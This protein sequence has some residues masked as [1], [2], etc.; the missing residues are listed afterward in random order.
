ME[1]TMKKVACIAAMLVVYGV[2]EG[3]KDKFHDLTC[4]DAFTVNVAQNIVVSIPDVSKELT[5]MFC[6]LKNDSAVR[7]AVS[8]LQKRID[9]FVSEYKKEEMALMKLNSSMWV[10]DVADQLG[11]L[12]PSESEYASKILEIITPMID[13]CE[14]TE[15]KHAVQL[16]KE[17]PDFYYC[18]G[19][20]GYYAI[21]NS[22]EFEKLKYLF[23]KYT[24]QKMSKDN[25]LELIKKSN[26]ENAYW[27]VQGLGS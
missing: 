8:V 13:F 5:A 6:N 19:L 17:A 12:D 10:K 22:T 25:A 27:F 26:C 21:E 23:E 2:S 18:F 11:A 4:K 7:K 14:K 9:D 16:I 24:E 20:I 15:N 1:V 3:M